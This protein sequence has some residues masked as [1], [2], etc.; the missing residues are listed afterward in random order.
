MDGLRN[1]NTEP[2][3]DHESLTLLGLAKSTKQTTPLSGIFLILGMAIFL[4]SQTVMIPL[5][6]A[7]AGGNKNMNWNIAFLPIWIGDGLTALCLIGAMISACCSIVQETASSSSSPS[8]SENV[9]TDEEVDKEKKDKINEQDTIL[10]KNREMVAQGPSHVN[11][12]KH[13]LTSG[14][15]CPFMFLPPLPILALL[16]AFHISLWRYFSKNTERP[17]TL[18]NVFLPLYIILGLLLIPAILCYRSGSMLNVLFLLATIATTILLPYKIEG[19]AKVTT[20]WG[21]ILLPFLIC[22]SLLFLQLLYVFV[23][24]LLW[25]WNVRRRLRVRTAVQRWAL[26]GYLVG[27]S[28]FIGGGCSIII[29]LDRAQN[30]IFAKSG[31]DGILKVL[32]LFLGVLICVIC[33]IAVACDIARDYIYNQNARPAPET[34]E[35]EDIQVINF[36]CFY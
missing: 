13:V 28:F 29:K 6:A 22:T 19:G 34:E 14:F 7:K 9:T 27:L 1:T 20:E 36:F 30:G 2:T 24:D 11:H 12:I 8:S 16:F 3:I 35:E 18:W 25:A 15:C 17:I 26:F 5:F 21:V 31:V 10:Q 33:M 32:P 4:I 23:N